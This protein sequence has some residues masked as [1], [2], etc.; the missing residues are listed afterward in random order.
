M[1]NENRVKICYT[2]SLFIS[3]VHT[4]ISHLHFSF[5]ISKAI[6]DSLVGDMRF[7]CIRMFAFDVSPSTT[8]TA[9]TKFPNVLL[10][11][12]SSRSWA[13]TILIWTMH[14]NGYATP[15]STLLYLQV[16]RDTKHWMRVPHWAGEKQQI[17]RYNDECEAPW[18][19]QQ[20]ICIDDRPP[21]VCLNVLF[22]FSCFAFSVFFFSSSSFPFVALP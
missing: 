10:F 22:A 20:H 18:R 5:R 2:H 4:H 11:E 16:V 9:T 15:K 3:P 1:A 13:F 19:Q 12:S 7:T 8:Y 14:P 6:F 21:F 17:K